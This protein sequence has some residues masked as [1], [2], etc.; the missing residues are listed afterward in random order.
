M[1]APTRT[2]TNGEVT[3]EWRPELCIHCEACFRG[4]PA[5]FDPSKRPWVNIQGATSDEI[6]KQVAECPSKALSL[7]WPA[8]CG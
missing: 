8:K 5:V 4:L 3:V 7:K 1:T 2:Y 6:E